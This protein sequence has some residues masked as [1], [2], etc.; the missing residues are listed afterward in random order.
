MQEK[1]LLFDSATWLVWMA[2]LAGIL[3]AAAT[4]RRDPRVEGERVLRHDGPAILAHW[5]HGL[6][7]AVL[8][9]S[10]LS[11]GV[12]FVPSVLAGGQ[13]VWTAMNIHFVAV[14]VFLFGTFYYGANSLLAPKRWR[15]HLP[16]KDALEYTKQHY[17]LLL[18]FK[19]FKMPPERKYFESEKMAYLMAGAATLTIIVTGMLKVAA[20]AMNVPGFVMAVA[21]PAHDI[22]TVVM[23]AFFF[24]HIFFAAILPSSWPIFRSMFTGYVSLDYAKHE[25]R[26]WLAELESNG[27]PA[28]PEGA[29]QASESDE[30]SA[31]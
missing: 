16:T 1:Q 30:R 12:L 18:G 17:G 10:G 25:H 9:V 21:T 7:T 24:P 8:L 4:R 28:D 26:G 11:L 3:L 20:H 23:L 22:A 29:D 15:E 5:T 13:P 6:G 27:R 19:Q 31:A 14:V 2:P